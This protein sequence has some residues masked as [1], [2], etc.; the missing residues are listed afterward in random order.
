MNRIVGL[1]LHAL[2]LHTRVHRNEQELT[3][4]FKDSFRVSR[5]A[6]GSKLVASLTGISAR[7]K[8]VFVIEI[9]LGGQEVVIPIPAG[10]LKTVC[11]VVPPGPHSDV[12]V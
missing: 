3:R 10:C 12:I 6:Q 5:R 11:E 2:V 8:V 7:S 9:Q 1:L 4:A